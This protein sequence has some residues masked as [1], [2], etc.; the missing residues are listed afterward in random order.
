MFFWFVTI[1]RYLLAVLAALF[2]SLVI[3]YLTIQLFLPS[4]ENYVV[5]GLFWLFTFLAEG[6]LLVPLSLAVTAEFV[7]SRALARRFSWH[8]ARKRFLVAI[9]IAIGP[10]YTTLFV[11]LRVEDRRPAHWLT[12]AVLLNCTSAVFAYLALRTAKQTMTSKS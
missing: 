11:V 7:E 3:S 10:I 6:I 12:I 5:G 2:S 9:P 4:D 1:V 8:K